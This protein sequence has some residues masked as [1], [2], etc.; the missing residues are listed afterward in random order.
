MT[1]SAC[2]YL[3]IFVFIAVLKGFIIKIFF[4]KFG[5]TFC[6]KNVKHCAIKIFTFI[7]NILVSDNIMP[8]I[9]LTKSHGNEFFNLLC[10]FLVV[11]ILKAVI[12]DL[13][14]VNMSTLIAFP[15]PF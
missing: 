15:P 9:I 11:W 12:K 6:T 5:N 1:I 13:M 2:P 7:E 3:L 8:T 4:S 14:F 10:I